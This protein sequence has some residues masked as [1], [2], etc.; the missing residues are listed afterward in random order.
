MGV[1]TEDELLV[2]L[3]PSLEILREREMALK[4]WW[5]NGR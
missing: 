1:R 5:E 3:L 2:L 4:K